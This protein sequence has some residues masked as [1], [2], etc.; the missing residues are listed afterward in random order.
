M[1]RG[2]QWDGPMWAS[3]MSLCA[4]R[5]TDIYTC[6]QARAL[7]AG[8]RQCHAPAARVRQGQSRTHGCQARADSCGKGE[9]RAPRCNA[10]AGEQHHRGSRRRARR[11]GRAG[12]RRGQSV[13]CVARVST[14]AK[15]WH[16]RPVHDSGGA[17][18][19]G[20]RGGGG[21]NVAAR[22][23]GVREGW[24]RE[25]RCASDAYTRRP[26]PSVAGAPGSAHLRDEFPCMT[27]PPSE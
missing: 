7:R 17:T 25:C 22:V 21:A 12:A 13:G 6:V 16:S 24:W 10:R 18:G 27:S 14:H 19:R 2:A 9:G 23:T 4:W 20:T 26:A 8:Q 15:Q 3:R 11:L 5:A 1:G